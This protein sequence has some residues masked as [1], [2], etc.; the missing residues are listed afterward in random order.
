MYRNIR[1]TM[2][3]LVLLRASKRER[4]RGGRNRISSAYLR[5][6]PRCSR[7]FNGRPVMYPKN[8]LTFSD[9]SFGFRRCTYERFED[10]SIGSLCTLIFRRLASHGLRRLPGIIQREAQKALEDGSFKGIAVGKPLANLYQIANHSWRLPASR[11]YKQ[12]SD[13]RKVIPG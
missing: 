8:P 13:R 11:V 6:C 10:R 1:S 4:R 9:T 2:A 7:Q 3:R 5:T 12:I